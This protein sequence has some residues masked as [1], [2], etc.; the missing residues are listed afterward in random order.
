MVYIFNNDDIIQQILT[1]KVFFTVLDL[2]Y[3]FIS[4]TVHYIYYFKIMNISRTKFNILQNC[5]EAAN[6]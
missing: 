4:C 1:G 6:K 5:F 2:G 3:L